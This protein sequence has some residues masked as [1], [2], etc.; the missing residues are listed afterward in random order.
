MGI[1]WVL[2]RKFAGTLKLTLG[3]LPSQKSMNA[4]LAHILFCQKIHGFGV[5]IDM[6]KSRSFNKSYIFHV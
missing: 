1:L 4:F 2:L 3:V 5:K 6:F